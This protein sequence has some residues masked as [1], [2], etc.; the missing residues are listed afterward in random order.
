VSKRFEKEF[1]PLGR[2]DAIVKISASGIFRL[3]DACP[4]AAV[5]SHTSGPDLLVADWREQR[6]MQQ[7]IRW[8]VV[9]DG[10]RKMRMKIGM[11]E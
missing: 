4:P 9:M 5:I 3:G 2:V 6:L 8:R 11:R 10:V 7:V 1:R